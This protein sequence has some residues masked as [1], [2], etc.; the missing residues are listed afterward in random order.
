MQSS[1]HNISDMPYPFYT[2]EYVEWKEF[3]EDGE[4]GASSVFLKSVRNVRLI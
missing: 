3:A 2:P 4:D 1:I